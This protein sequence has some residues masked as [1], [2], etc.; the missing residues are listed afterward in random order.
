MLGMA[1]KN[2]NARTSRN[3]FLGE[4]FESLSCGVAG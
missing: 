2:E 3:C 1:S 4:R